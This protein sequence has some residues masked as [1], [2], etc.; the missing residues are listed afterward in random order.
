MRRNGIRVHGDLSWRLDQI[1]RQHGDTAQNL[2]QRLDSLRT[3]LHADLEV[4]TPTCERSLPA[5]E[6]LN[7][8]LENL[9][10][11]VSAGQN[12]T[13][14]KLD[15]IGASLSQMRVGGVQVRSS[16]VVQAPTEDVLAR[17]FR[18]ELR[19]V[20]MPTVEQC[21]QKFKA[22]PDSQLA[23]I[24]RKIDEM[25]QQMGSNSG[26]DVHDNFTPINSTL[27][28]VSSAPA[29]NHQPLAEL[30]PSCD[31]GSTA[32]GV[33]KWEKKSNSRHINRWRLSWTYRWTIGTLWVTISR[34]TTSRKISPEYRLGE[35]PCP[36]KAYR[37]TIEFLPAPLLI[38]LRGL[39]LSVT[40]TQNQRGYNQICPLIST[41]AVVSM[42]AEV[43]RFARRNDVKGIQSLFE[44]RLAAPSDRDEYGL[45]PLMV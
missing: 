35:I 17:V 10:E 23:E 20:I 26:G 2:D 32:F 15:A 28:E 12:V 38:Q 8:G 30:A 39:T 22:N 7:T 37:V 11:L 5:Q 45:T 13:N 29:R 4:I 3:G 16:T 41:F 34:T 25:T 40:N 19:R 18:A 33:P 31:L 24:R 27:Q 21:F 6:H 42:F 43:M 1:L 36:R 9:Q 14:D 44:R